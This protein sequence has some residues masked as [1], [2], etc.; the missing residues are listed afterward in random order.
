MQEDE[1]FRDKHEIPPKSR[2]KPEINANSSKILD[3]DEHFARELQERERIEYAQSLNKT[4]TT[5]QGEKV[6]T[7]INK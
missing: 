4:S 2:R 3:D 6:R 5:C 1:I 7:R